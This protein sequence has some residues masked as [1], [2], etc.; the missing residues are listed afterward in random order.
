MPPVPKASFLYA[1][2]NFP[3]ENDVL[4]HSHVLNV[5][6]QQCAFE[7]VLFLAERFKHYVSFSKN[8]MSEMEQ[9]FMCLQSFTLD[10]FSEE[11]RNEATIRVNE[12]GDSV[13]FH[14]DVLWYYLFLMKILGCSKSKFHNLFKLAKIILVI[15]HSN[16]EEEGLFLRVRKNLKQLKGLVCL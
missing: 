2:N 8:E 10:N 9:E 15:V 13:T 6:H 5:L 7:S 14:I 16:A 11:A 3:L 1:V 12:D 4:E